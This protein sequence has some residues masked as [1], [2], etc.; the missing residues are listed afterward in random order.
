MGLQP[1]W[2]ET[3]TT[4][5]PFDEHLAGF[6]I[7]FGDLSARVAEAGRKYDEVLTVFPTQREWKPDPSSTL[8]NTQQLL[9]AIRGHISRINTL[10]TLVP[11]KHHPGMDLEKFKTDVVTVEGNKDILNAVR[12]LRVVHPDFDGG[13]F[14]IEKFEA[15]KPFDTT[16]QALLD[17]VTH[18]RKIGDELL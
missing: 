2:N 12:V 1:Q 16:V 10:A 7:N 18:L 11:I 8:S 13:R 9:E 5:H 3:T 4:V 14:T 6:E 15:M 17:Q